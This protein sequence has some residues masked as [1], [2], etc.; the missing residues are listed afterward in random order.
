MIDVMASGALLITR[1]APDSDLIRVFGADCPVPTYRNLD[2]LEQLC[3]HYLANED[4]R[5]E[6]VA[7]CNAL[8]GPDYSFAARARDLLGAVGL[9]PVEGAAPG[10]VRRMELSVLAELGWLAV[11]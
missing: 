11:A 2:E 1:H 4:E 7:R 3:A 5:R 8:V 10:R 9:E 6:V